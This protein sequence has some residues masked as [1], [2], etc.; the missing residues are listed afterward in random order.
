MI[1]FLQDRAARQQWQ[2]P[3][4]NTAFRTRNIVRTPNTANTNTTELSTLLI[5]Q[6][7]MNIALH[8]TKWR[9][10]VTF[11][12]LTPMEMGL[13]VDK[14][15]RTSKLISC[16]AI[17]DS[18]RQRAPRLINRGSSSHSGNKNRSKTRTDGYLVLQNYRE[19]LRWMKVDCN[20]YFNLNQNSHLNEKW[21]DFG[22]TS[23]SYIEHNDRNPLKPFH[24]KCTGTESVSQKFQHYSRTGT[25]IFEMNT[26]NLSK[27]L[28]RRFT[29]GW[30][31]F[32]LDD[33]GFWRTSMTKVHL[34]GAAGVRNLDP[35]RVLFFS[36]SWWRWRWVG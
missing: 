3:N 26:H 21:L 31:V 29:V 23:S 1:Q 24:F 28:K 18:V 15:R 30:W 22:C 17:W 12:T 32:T 6:S 11:S 9:L 10:R 2:N 7:I 33:W 20:T 35:V 16:P 8:L 4:L 34:K 14:A 27:R 13:T 5:N 25:A 19:V 36:S